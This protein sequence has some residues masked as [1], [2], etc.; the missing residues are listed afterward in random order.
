MM[1]SDNEFN[2]EEM[3]L[4]DLRTSA[5]KPTTAIG[6][7]RSRYSIH[8][9]DA[10]LVAAMRSACR[11]HE[12]DVGRVLVVIDDDDDSVLHCEA[13]PA[14]IPAKVG[15]TVEGLALWAAVGAMVPRSRDI[16]TRENSFSMFTSCQRAATAANNL[17]AA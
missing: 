4:L 10:R 7:L 14:Q 13:Y 9:N 6:R 16:M 3:L 8:G 11:E 15:G 12:K 2:I 17:A 5:I 1:I